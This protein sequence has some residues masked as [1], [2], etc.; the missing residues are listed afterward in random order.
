MR[1]QRT[2]GSILS[3]GSINADFQIRTRRRREASDTLLATDFA[4]LGG[5]KAANVAFLAGK[6]GRKAQ[7][8]AHTGDDDLAEQAIAPLRETGVD[9]RGI[10]KIRNGHTGVTM[11]TVPYEGKRS[12]VRAPNA[13]GFWC[14]DDVAPVISA[15]GAAEADSVLVV[16]CEIPAF[17]VEQALRAAR[18][19]G[20]RTVL[21]PSAMSRV[22][23]ALLKLAD[24][25]VL[26]TSAATAL[27]GVTCSDIDSVI[28]AAQSL[29][30]R[31]IAVACIKLPQ[32]GC[33]LAE[34]GC[35]FHIA[36]VPVDVVD[37]TGAGDAF[38]GALV[39]A[40]LEKRPPHQAARFAVA[41]SHLAVTAYGS[42]PAYPTREQI[43][44][45]ERRLDMHTHVWQP[46]H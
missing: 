23:D 17:V 35:A 22:N 19:R 42:Q 18:Q 39:V 38:T 12:V 31:G 7:L 14:P 21:A 44:R 15:I 25:I 2:A 10:K 37:T 27:T 40:L 24:V 6:L 34:D 26:K 3:L 43:E 33:V 30:E 20:M 13:N 1:H 45:L 8:F 11:I 29:L 9:L 36:P 46:V 5:G 41:A 16:D 4:R 28:I 32:G